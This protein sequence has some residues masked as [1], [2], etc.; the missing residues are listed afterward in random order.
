MQWAVVARV[1]LPRQA[2]LYSVFA[3][4]VDTTRIGMHTP[5]TAVCALGLGPKHH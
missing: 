1:I 5:K 4:R 2:G 3:P